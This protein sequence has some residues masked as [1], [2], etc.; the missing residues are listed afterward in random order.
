MH[1]CPAGVFYIVWFV[2]LDFF[3]KYMRS[4]GI[5]VSLSNENEM[6]RI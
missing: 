3:C 6:T 2:Y 1:W 5:R 4:G